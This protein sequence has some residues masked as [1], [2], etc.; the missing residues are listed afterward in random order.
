MNI[1]R[2]LHHPIKPDFH[3]IQPSATNYLPHSVEEG[4]RWE[5]YGSSSGWSSAVSIAA[6]GEYLE[7]KHFYLDV[8]VDETNTLN[9]NLTPVEV[10]DFQRAFA[11]TKKSPS[12]ID[13]TKHHFNLTKVV[14]VADFSACKIPTVCISI[15]PSTNKLDEKIYPLRD[16]CGC[17]AHSDLESA[18]YGALTETLERQ[19]LIRF[20]LTKKYA[21]KINS[22]QAIQALRH[23]PSR[24]LFQSLLG[25]GE[26]CALDI[27]D[28]K[29][30]GTCIL[31]C[32]GNKDTTSQI[33]YCAGMS[34][35]RDIGSALEKSVIELWQTYRFMQSFIASARSISTLEDPY[36]RH[37]LKCNTYETYAHIS[38]TSAWTK[39]A[40]NPTPLTIT[41]LIKTIRALNLNG[42]IYL[43]NLCTDGNNTFFSKYI[44]P[45]FFLHMNNASN[46]NMH[47]A[48]SHEFV[49]KINP[50]QKT[51]M[52]PFP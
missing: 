24:H 17:C 44:S 51:S 4:S 29:F 16:T 41:A 28:A 2:E 5:T 27:T 20:W 47:N 15:S 25:G 43:N 14:R 19:F 45:N 26:L 40:T 18:M 9:V 12:C 13:I 8:P 11:Q 30:P 35:A 21:R 46:I 39:Q 23:S 42:Y 49:D 10:Y 7:R 38:N 22:T 36:I 6:H 48:Y 34:Y 33:H 37:F 1:Y 31:L 52:V 3:F 50:T 32:Y